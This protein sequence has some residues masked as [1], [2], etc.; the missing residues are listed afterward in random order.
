[1]CRQ[2]SN[3]GA[4]HVVLSCLGLQ[5]YPP[6]RGPQDVTATA[7][8]I[9]IARNRAPSISKSTPGVIRTRDLRIRNPLL[10]PTELRGLVVIDLLFAASVRSRKAQHVNLSRPSG[11]RMQSRGCPNAALK[12]GQNGPILHGFPPQIGPVSV[13]ANTIQISSLQR[14]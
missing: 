11:Q 13:A 8:R 9:R 3:H 6:C 4:T 10:Y 7:V 14:I 2:I 12:V 5:D 1:K